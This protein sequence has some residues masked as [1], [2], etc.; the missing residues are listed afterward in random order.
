M[1]NIESNMTNLSE[2]LVKQLNNPI[3]RKI[4]MVLMIIL[5]IFVIYKTLVNVNKKALDQPFIFKGYHN[6]MEPLSYGKEL[7]ASLS[8][9]GYT[10]SYWM[11]VVDWGYNFKKPKHVFHIGD[12][13]G[14]NVSPGVWLYPENNDMMIRID[15][16]NRYD[17]RS[18][19]ISGKNCQ[20]WTNSIPH[21]NENYLSKNYPSADLG[22]HNYC[23]NP[24]NRKS[25][26][27]CYTQDPKVETESCGFQDHKIP[28]SMNPM[29][30]S[31][32]LDSE[33][34]CDIINIPI[35]RW[36]HVSIILDNKT[37]DVYLNGKLKRS[38]TYDNVPKIY[39]KNVY[40]TQDGGFKGFLSDMQYYNKP[41]SANQVYNTYL[42][43]PKRVNALHLI[44]SLIPQV[45]LNLKLEISD[46]SETSKDD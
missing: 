13:E 44:Q 30:N 6:A 9:L 14:N 22:D 31:S 23:R 33:K 38:C 1:N 39:N 3:L 25:G 28:P 42:S 2:N 43:S 27:W 41:L 10:L 18:K 32:M 15:T 37:L 4:F 17:N 45:G 12:S 35:Q 16:H 40:V 34:D 36:I 5:I 8:G 29:N 26:T 19:T 21:T 11:Y 24:D 20:N 46:D 7:P